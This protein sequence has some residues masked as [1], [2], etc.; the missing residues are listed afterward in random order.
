MRLM[1]KYGGNVGNV[2]ES[3]RLPFVTGQLEEKVVKYVVIKK[4]LVK[5]D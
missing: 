3:G 2:D 1:I 4:V 5:E